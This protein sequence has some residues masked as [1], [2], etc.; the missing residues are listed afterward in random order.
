[1]G[2][3]IEAEVVHVQAFRAE[4]VA[5]RSGRWRR[6]CGGFG[7]VTFQDVLRAP[8][9]R[10]RV[11]SRRG[12][13]R[14]IAGSSGP[15][16]RPS[17][18]GRGRSRRRWPA[19]RAAPWARPSQPSGVRPSRGGRVRRLRRAPTATRRRA[20]RRDG[21]GAAPGQG[22]I[23]TKLR[24]DA[25]EQRSSVRSASNRPLATFWGLSAIAVP[26][27]R[28]RMA[29]LMRPTTPRPNSAPIASPPPTART[30]SATTQEGRSVGERKGQGARDERTSAR[31][32]ED[33]QARPG[34]DR[35][36]TRL[37]D[38]VGQGQVPVLDADQPRHI[39][40]PRPD[41]QG[42]AYQGEVPPLH[43]DQS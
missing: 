2:L 15:G 21:P 17:E 37:Q 36:L 29:E 16:G 39:R 20:T 32:S 27:P 19:R 5:R 4:S 40:R 30:Q 7:P 1:M 10:S 6:A 25:I 42:D 34:G 26:S 28:T 9:S 22:P 8:G 31:C 38:A 41:R 43:L 3:G 35:A 13:C 18:V 24:S 14:P 12:R 11:P 33:D 23:S